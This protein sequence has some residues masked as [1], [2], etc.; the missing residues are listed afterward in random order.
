MD[1]YVSAA[2]GIVDEGITRSGTPL[3]PSLFE[4]LTIAVSRMFG[5]PVAP[6]RMTVRYYATIEA[7]APKSEVRAIGDDCLVACGLFPER[8]L[9]TGSSIS[10]YVGLGRNAYDE[11][12][13]SE[14]SSGFQ[15]MVDVLSPFATRSAQT[16]IQLAL[17]GASGAGRELKSG[18]VL[19]FRR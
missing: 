1:A 12:G 16:M 18:N 7:G 19:L 6:E 11:V 8:I 14:A 2:R 4:H 10:H 5:A 13:L 9:T 15:H 3:T 17:A